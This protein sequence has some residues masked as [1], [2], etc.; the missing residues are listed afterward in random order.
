MSWYKASRNCSYM[1]SESL[2]SLN[3]HLTLFCKP[4][5]CACILFFK[6]VEVKAA[7]VFFLLLIF[8]EVTSTIS[9]FHL[10]VPVERGTFEG[11]MLQENKFL[12]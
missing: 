9:I 6:K 4:C 2:N 5:V 12:I 11:D 7:P 8:I 10:V 3:F 1:Y